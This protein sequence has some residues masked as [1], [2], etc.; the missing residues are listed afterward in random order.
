MGGASFE[1][2]CA[3]QELPL[4]VVPPGS[5]KLQSH[6]ERAQ[7]TYREEF[8][9]VY[10]VELSLEA[11]RHQLQEWATI[12]NTVRPHQHLNYLTPLEYCQ[13]HAA[14]KG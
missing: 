13:R 12:Y 14:G 9:Q 3:A 7:R 6:V 5:P 2:A 4:Y 1:A 10:P 8:Y 11:H